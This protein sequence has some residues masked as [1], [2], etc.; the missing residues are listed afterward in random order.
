MLQ[1]LP[2]VAGRGRIGPFPVDEISDV[3]L[4]LEIEIKIAV[5]VVTL[6]ENIADKIGLPNLPRPVNHQGLPR[7]LLVPCE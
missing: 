7:L 6:G 5:F 3:I 1:D 2:R 4:E